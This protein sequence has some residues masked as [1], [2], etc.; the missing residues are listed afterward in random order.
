M[1]PNIEFLLFKRDWVYLCSLK[2]IIVGREGRSRKKEEE[3][4]KEGKKEE[5]K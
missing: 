1:C 2:H 5:R 3:E 4:K